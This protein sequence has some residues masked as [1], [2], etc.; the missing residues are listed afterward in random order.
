MNILLYIA[1]EKTTKQC[2]KMPIG[3]PLWVTGFNHITFLTKKL[4]IFS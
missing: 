4:S 3:H 1:V 2:T